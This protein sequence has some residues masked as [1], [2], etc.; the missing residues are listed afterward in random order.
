VLR[1]LLLPLKAWL[2]LLLL[3]SL[4]ENLPDRKPSRGPITPVP[5]QVQVR[6][7]GRPVAL[8]RELPRVTSVSALFLLCDQVGIKVN[9]PVAKDSGHDA[10]TKPEHSHLIT[11]QQPRQ[12]DGG[13]PRGFM[14]S[15]CRIQ[16]HQA[17]EACN[18][19]TNLKDKKEGGWAPNACR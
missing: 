15:I 4:S 6:V 5:L 10:A 16:G 11:L 18:L 13:G 8:P 3:L 19:E 17:R 2:S 9:G 7:C 12:Q 1:R 14:T